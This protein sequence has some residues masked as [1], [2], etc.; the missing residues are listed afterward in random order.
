MDDIELLALT[1]GAVLIHLQFLKRK[2][3]LL[4]YFF[5]N[6]TVSTYIYS[7][8]LPGCAVA[9]EHLSDL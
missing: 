4:M 7:L 1:I 3:V 6:F 8:Y 9:V 5:F 2:K